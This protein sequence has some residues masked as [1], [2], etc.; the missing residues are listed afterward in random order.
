MN[1]LYVKPGENKTVL[2]IYK[3]L[4]LMFVGIA[5]RCNKFNL[6]STK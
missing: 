4:V 5:D 2:T 1:A 6:K 3:Q